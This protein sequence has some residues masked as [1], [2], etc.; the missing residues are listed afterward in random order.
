MQGR[1]V[2]KRWRPADE[3]ANS[4]LRGRWVGGRVARGETAGGF[5]DHGL[6][7]FEKPTSSSVAP[8]PDSGIPGEG[9][10]SAVRN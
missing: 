1:A 9:R 8:S 10:Q 5:V 6:G 4:A 3:P 7:L 2:K